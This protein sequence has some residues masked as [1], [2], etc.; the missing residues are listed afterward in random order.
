MQTRKIVLQIV[1]V[2][3]LAFL[4]RYFVIAPYRVPTPS[5]THTLLPGDC[6]LANKLAYKLPGILG[7]RRNDVVIFQAPEDSKKV[8]TKR[9]VAIG[10][11]TIE[12]KGKKLFINLTQTDHA[13]AWFS[14]PEVLPKG[15]YDNRDNLKKITLPQNQVFILGDNRDDSLDSRVWGCLDVKT[16]QAKVLFI[17]WSKNPD[18]GR[19]RLG[20]IGKQIK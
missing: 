17:Y 1:G 18:N 10:G 3:F 9:I 5:M 6:V 12:I 16:I 14:D 11:D 20:R 7:P 4:L 2:F 13:F 8:Y 19:W 15:E